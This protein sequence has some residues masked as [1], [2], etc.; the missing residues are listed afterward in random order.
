M[1]KVLEVLTS[2]MLSLGLLDVL[3][4]LNIVFY[5]ER[6]KHCSNTN[7]FGYFLNAII[8]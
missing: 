1:K 2:K 5:S 4:V 8:S 6:N 7:I 3:S